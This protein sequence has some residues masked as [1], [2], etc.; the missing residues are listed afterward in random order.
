MPDAPP[1]RPGVPY[2]QQQQ[3]WLPPPAHLRQRHDG[4]APYLGALPQELPCI[5]NA[6]RLLLLLALLAAAPLLLLI[7]CRRRAARPGSRRRRVIAAAAAGCRRRRLHC[8]T[9]RRQRR[10]AV[11][12]LRGCTIAAVATAVAGP[13]RR[14]VGAIQ[15]AVVEPLHRCLQIQRRM[16]VLPAIGCRCAGRRCL[17]CRRR[18][19]AQ[20]R[21]R[22][23]LRVSRE[24]G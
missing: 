14:R 11:A 18:F 1:Q 17:A 5:R 8:G 7:R 23:A 22:G 21:S 15:A 9:L 20:P 16:V 6:H 10:R 2:Q 3:P 4:Q 19:S 12:M 24:G 13:R